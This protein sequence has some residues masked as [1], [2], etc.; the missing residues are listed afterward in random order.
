MEE[1]SFEWRGLH[2]PCRI[3]I[4]YIIHGPNERFERPACV[5]YPIESQKVVLF[6]PKSRTQYNVLLSTSTCMPYDSADR[7]C[8][9]LVGFG[10]EKICII[11]EQD[12]VTNIKKPL[13]KKRIEL[14]EG[15]FCD[16][17]N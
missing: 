2:C 10:E 8:C 5:V 13:L 9:G 11:F 4:P 15:H 3:L 12:Y 14:D 6:L 16:Y 17:R 7:G 1:S